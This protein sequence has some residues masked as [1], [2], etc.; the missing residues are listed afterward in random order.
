M[1]GKAATYRGGS[2]KFCVPVRRCRH[3]IHVIRQPSSFERIKM[4]EIAKLFLAQAE[5]R[6]PCNIYS[7]INRLSPQFFS[8][9]ENHNHNV[10]CALL[11]AVLIM[12]PNCVLTNNK[13]RYD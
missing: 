11:S 10:F 4:D 12:S 2:S 9:P 8:A 6:N 7:S 3:S 5:S 1:W 13:S